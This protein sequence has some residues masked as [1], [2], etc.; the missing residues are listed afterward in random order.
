MILDTMEKNTKS[1]LEP[2]VGPTYFTRDPKDQ[3]RFFGR[4]K[5]SEEIVSL[6][7][8]HKLVLIYAQ[9][10]AG[11]TSIFEAQVARML[12]KYGHNV[13]PRTR[14]GVA[15]NVKPELTSTSNNDTRT[16]NSENFYMFNA[17]QS[18]LPSQENKSQPLCNMTLDQFL[19][20]YIFVKSNTDFSDDDQDSNLK[21]TVL[22]FD[23]LEEIFSYYPNGRNWREEQVGFFKEVAEALKKN[24]FLRIVF[25]I[26]EDYLA[27]LDRFVDYLPERLRPRFRL[28][29]LNKEA[30]YE[31]IKGPLENLDKNIYDHKEIDIK[32]KEI[33]KNLS[34]IRVESASPEKTTDEPGWLEGEFVEPLQL[35]VVCQRRWKMLF[36]S[37]Y[38]H[39]HQDELDLLDVDTALKE[40]YEEAIHKAAK[41]TNINEKDIREL[42][43]RKLITSNGMRAF[44]HRGDFED[45]IY[46][47]KGKHSLI[48][49]LLY[50][51]RRIGI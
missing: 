47:D 46:N 33:V 44:V 30:A 21:P 12:Q 13:L 42:F 11:K 34:K 8:A 14:V 19:M 6:I 4:N 26:R 9:S 39:T 17:F 45:V 20:R 43:N 25:I 5:E 29:R 40:F 2:Y 50:V 18:L 27:E 36:S 22:L 41:Q 1:Q 32:I 49:G 7:L 3:A 23:Q 38:S 31:A 16:R 28:E 24:N 51:K 37:Q 15:S 35:Q 10:G 48:S